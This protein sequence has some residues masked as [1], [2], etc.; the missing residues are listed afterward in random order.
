MKIHFGFMEN[1]G[2]Y[3]S[4]CWGCETTV[5]GCTGENAIENTVDDWEEVTCKKCL[6]LKAAVIEGIKSDEEAIVHQMGEMADFFKKEKLAEN[7]S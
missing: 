2:D 5:C 1:Y 3:E 4:P 7:F 6:R